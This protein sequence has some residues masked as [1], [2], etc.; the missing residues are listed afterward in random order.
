MYSKIVIV[1]GG[2]GG[3]ELACKLGRKLGPGHVMLVDSRTFH[4]WKPS[5]HEVAAGT[6]DIHQE[7]LSYQMLAHDNGF[8]FVYGALTA[9]DTVGNSLT[10]GPISAEAQQELLPERQ[11]SYASL[12]LAI[13]STSNY[14]GVP[15]ARDYTISLNATED[16]ERFRLKLLRLMTSAELRKD[17]Q[18]DAGVNIVIIGGGAT[19]VEL[20]AELREASSAYA[21]Y[22]FHHLQAL[23]DVRITLL[24]GAPRILAPLP[25]KVSEAALKLLH[26]RGIT[27]A[28]ET[29]VTAIDHDCV[30]TAAGIVYPADICVWAAGIKAPELLS[31]LGLPTNRAGQVEVDGKLA[32]KGL[33]NVYALGDCAACQDVDGKLVPPR[34]QAAH[35]QADYLLKTFALQAAGKPAQTKPYVYRDYGSLVSFGQTTTVG[36][37]MGSLKGLSWFVEGFIARMMYIGLHLM[38]HRAVLGLVRT[39]VLALARFL[40][41]RTTPVVKL[42]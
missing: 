32:V 39:G 17:T 22:D 5:L 7:G 30:S 8:T 9:L 16:A 34:A 37:L 28:T 40:I 26:E 25:E 3:L 4:I 29:K 23:R 38:H 11:I 27:V 33:A 14:F 42:H 18:A 10:V 35:Q 20:A 21:Q 31:Q 13:G 15:G 36:S 2:A 12:V 41:K 19:G 1:G 24:E 6:L